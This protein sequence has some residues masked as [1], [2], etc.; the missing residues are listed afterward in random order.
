MDWRWWPLAREKGVRCAINP[1]AHHTSQL[2]FLHF[3]VG[4]ARKGWMTREDV[5]NCLPL[6]KVTTLLQAK[7]GR[8]R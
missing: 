8:Q 6:E 7:R 5:V 1:D 3:G 2:Q 4:L